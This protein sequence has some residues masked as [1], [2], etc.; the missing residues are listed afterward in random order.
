MRNEYDCIMETLRTFEWDDDYESDGRMEEEED[1]GPEK[2]GGGHVLIPAHLT[3]LQ[4]SISHEKH[5]HSS[6]PYR[7]EFTKSF[8]MGS[9][10]FHRR[11]ME[12]QGCKLMSMFSLSLQPG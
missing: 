6:R 7:T 3:L 4:R 9:L 5:L 1:V 11:Y 2:V 12:H 10:D 8:P